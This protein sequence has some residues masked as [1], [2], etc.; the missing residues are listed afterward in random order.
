MRKT[1]NYRVIRLSRFKSLTHRG[2]T[3]TTGRMW[4]RSSS[5]CVRIPRWRISSP[6]LL[7]LC[8]HLLRN[9]EPPDKEMKTLKT[10]LI[11]LESAWISI[12]SISLFSICLYSGRSTIQPAGPNKTRRLSRCQ[13]W[14]WLLTR[15][16]C[17]PF[18]LPLPLYQSLRSDS[19]QH[20]KHHQRHRRM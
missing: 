18:S 8:Q 17:P 10:S 14:T 13:I 16:S 9:L 5:A 3:L 7:R 20:D 4:K 19:K 12:T 15:P 6:L 2:K 11:W 1:A